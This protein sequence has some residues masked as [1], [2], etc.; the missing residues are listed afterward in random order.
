MSKV[1]IKLVKSGIHCPE[2]QKKTLRALGLTR[3]NKTV[4]H[5]S[6]SQINGMITKVKHLVAIENS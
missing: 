1:K 2:R 6:N 3:L 5:E 4:E